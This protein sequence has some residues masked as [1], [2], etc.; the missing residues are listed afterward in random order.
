MTK[1]K[2]YSK[3]QLYDLYKS[4]DIC[5]IIATKASYIDDSSMVTDDLKEAKENVS[6]GQH[7]FICTRKKIVD[8]LDADWLYQRFIDSMEE[9]GVEGGYLEGLIGGKGEEDFKSTITKFV[10]R[11]VKDS[12]ISDEIIGVL[13]A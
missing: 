9:E 3:E 12:W 10:K 4:S 7:I 6:E 1:L 13:E 11:Y 5:F 2:R 8:C